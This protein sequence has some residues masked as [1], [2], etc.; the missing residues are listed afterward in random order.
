MSDSPTSLPKGRPAPGAYCVPLNALIAAQ[1]LEQMRA[2]RQ[3][4][5]RRSRTPPSSLPAIYA[6]LLRNTEQGVTGSVLRR[7]PGSCI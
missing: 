1:P 3:Q 5:A 4:D 7:L 6:L 2:R